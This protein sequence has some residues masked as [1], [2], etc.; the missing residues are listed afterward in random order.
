MTVTL[1]D[2]P[3]GKGILVKKYLVV[4][5]LSVAALVVA[6]TGVSNSDAQAPGP[7]KLVLKEGKSL[8]E[9]FVYQKPLARKG[10][11]SLGD[12]LLFNSKLFNEIKQPVGS[13]EVNCTVV[14][15]GSFEAGK[16]VTL[17][18]GVIHLGN[19]Y[20]P[21]HPTGGDIFLS[22]RFKPSEDDTN[23]VVTGA[24]TGGT[25]VYANAH[26]TFTSVGEPATDTLTFTTG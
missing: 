23:Q 4:F 20:L 19:G 8:Q 15:A 13:I 24:I 1:A 11:A 22:A 21:P 17:C 9:R 7:Q 25:G 6:I 3:Q 10:N 18:N 16:T 26:G 5:A 14:V 12:S 2:K